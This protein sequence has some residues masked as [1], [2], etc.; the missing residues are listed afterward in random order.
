M[1]RWLLNFGCEEELNLLP[2]LQ[3]VA[4]LSPFL[5]LSTQHSLCV[6]FHTLWLGWGKHRICTSGGFEEE[7]GLFWG[8]SVQVS[9]PWVQSHL[10]RAF[11]SLPPPYTSQEGMRPYLKECLPTCECNLSKG[12]VVITLH[13]FK[14]HF[15]LWVPRSFTKPLFGGGKRSIQ[16]LFT[17]MG[18]A[19]CET[20]S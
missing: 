19:R 5:L 3:R 18:Q 13:S 7:V 4:D 16:S 10:F 2:A 9:R 15:C 20:P 1:I 6:S 8:G 12:P 14:G 17:V 11:P